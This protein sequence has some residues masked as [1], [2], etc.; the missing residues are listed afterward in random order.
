MAVR[1]L[2]PGRKRRG[3]PTAFWL[4][5]LVGVLA[6]LFVLV[7]CFA[8]TGQ[9]RRLRLSAAV[10]GRALNGYMRVVANAEQADGSNYRDDS[11]TIADAADGSN[12]SEGDEAGSELAD[13]S[14]LRDDSRG[15]SEV[16]DGSNYR[17]PAKPSRPD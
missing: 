15:I 14:S 13:G 11:K 3:R 10:C 8:S 9:V 16:A 12:Y 2:E 4:W 1:L 17:E 6:V 7:G 5:S